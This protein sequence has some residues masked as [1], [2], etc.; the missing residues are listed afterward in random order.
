MKR[1]LWF[2]GLFFVFCLGA[3]HP[4]ASQSIWSWQLGFVAKVGQPTQRIGVT[5]G[6]RWQY[7][8]GQ[9]G[10]TWAGLQNIRAL[11][12]QRYTLE[13]QLRLRVQGGWGHRP[14]DR[15]PS[16]DVLEQWP[17]AYRLGYQWNWYWDD[18]GT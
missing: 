3:S 9:L 6:V 16:F 12:T 18:Q 7:S 17:A 13:H 10:A 4:A 2:W 8:F 14:A 1:E 11:G 15:L 5:A